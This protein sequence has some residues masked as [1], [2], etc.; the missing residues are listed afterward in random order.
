MAQSQ[1][2]EIKTVDP[3]TKAYLTLT[4]YT[5]ID[6]DG[7]PLLRGKWDYYGNDTWTWALSRH[8]RICLQI[9][10]GDGP[11]EKLRF[12]NENGKWLD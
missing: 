2:R 7:N 4:Y 11:R 5:D 1:Y 9:S 3:K 6:E 12:E 8:Y 10:K